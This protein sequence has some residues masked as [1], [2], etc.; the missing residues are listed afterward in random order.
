MNF[1]MRTATPDDVFI[2]ETHRRLRW[3]R[4][5]LDF[6][7]DAARLMG[8][9]A[10]HLEVIRN[11]CQALKLYRHNGF[12]ERNRFLMARWVNQSQ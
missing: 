6:V 12:K 3:S 1:L 4:R 8:V 5:A 2:R 7:E 11:N 9:K 10:I